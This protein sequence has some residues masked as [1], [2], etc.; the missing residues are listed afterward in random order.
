MRSKETGIETLDL[1]STAV[2]PNFSTSSFL[3]S[4]LL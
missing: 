3:N 4:D 2:N 1:G